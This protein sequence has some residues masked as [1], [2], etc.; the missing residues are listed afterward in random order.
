M[1]DSKP[2]KIRKKYVWH[3]KQLLKSHL[4]NWVIYLTRQYLLVTVAKGDED[5]KWIQQNLFSQ[6]VY[7]LVEEID[8]KQASSAQNI[9]LS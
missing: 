7:N 6:R 9:S 1:A 8:K 2:W 3:K 5:K 4:C